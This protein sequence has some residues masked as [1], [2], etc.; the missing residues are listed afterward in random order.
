MLIEVDNKGTIDFCNNRS[1]ASQTRH[2]KVKQ[3]YLCKLQNAVILKVK[4]KTD[5]I[6]IGAL[7]TKQDSIKIS[8]ALLPVQL[9]PL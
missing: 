6:I 4:W 3:Y 9:L 7:F 1:V 5:D 2:I 8:E